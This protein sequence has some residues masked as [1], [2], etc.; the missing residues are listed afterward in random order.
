MRKLVSFLALVLSGAAWAENATPLAPLDVSSARTFYS[1]HGDR[2]HSLLGQGTQPDVV[3]TCLSVPAG[4]LWP[5]A[6]GR[7][8]DEPDLFALPGEVTCK[9]LA[10]VPLRLTLWGQGADGVFHPRVQAGFDLR[11]KT[12]NTLWIDWQQEAPK[13]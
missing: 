3:M 10:P 5:K 7:G 6:L 12:G 9:P 13:P 1:I 2:V 4:Q 11:G 8:T